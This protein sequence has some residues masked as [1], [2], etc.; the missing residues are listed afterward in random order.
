[1]C[2]YIYI[3]IYICIKVIDNA[4]IRAGDVIVGLASSGKAEFFTS[5]IVDYTSQ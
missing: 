4:Q 1:M 2:I 5:I 3:Y